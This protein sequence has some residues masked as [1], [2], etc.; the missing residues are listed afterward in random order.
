MADKLD[1][2][3]RSCHTE[4]GGNDQAQDYEEEIEVYVTDKY[5]ENNANKP[6]GHDD[7]DDDSDDD[8]NDDDHDDDNDDDNDNDND[9]DNDD[10]D[11]AKREE[12]YIRFV[13]SL[14]FEETASGDA[15]K[16]L[17]FT[18]EDDDEVVQL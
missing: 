11:I 15:Y 3:F 1:N 7:S 6:Y 4:L 16:H 12:D 5:E 10:D 17:P 13:T 18:E 8:N 9:D 2:N 14:S